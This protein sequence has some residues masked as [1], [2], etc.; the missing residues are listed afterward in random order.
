MGTQLILYGVSPYHVK[1]K[2][3][4]SDL[5]TDAQKGSAK[6]EGE[7]AVDQKAESTKISGK[8]MFKRFCSQS[9]KTLSKSPD[10]TLPQSSP[11]NAFSRQ[12]FSN[13]KMRSSAD[14]KN[15]K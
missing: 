3:E 2:Q 9:T 11:C 4:A 15:Y 10:L 5:L 8:C 7:K 14:T 1:G 13:P 12:V 6:P